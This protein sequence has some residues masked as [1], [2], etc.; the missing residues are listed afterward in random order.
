[1]KSAA[2]TARGSCRAFH[3][4]VSRLTSSGLPAQGSLNCASHFTLRRA[5]FTRVIT[6]LTE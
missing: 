2:A 1:M 3:S 5:F 4:L 6:A